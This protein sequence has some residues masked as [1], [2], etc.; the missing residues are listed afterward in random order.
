MFL[1]TRGALL[2]VTKSLI[3]FVWPPKQSIC[4]IIKK[5]FGG[6]L[7][8]KSDIKKAFDTM[9]WKFLPQVIQAFGLHHTFC[10]W[11]KIILQSAKL[12]I[13][14]NGHSVGYF[15]CK[16]GVRQVIL[17]PCFFFVL[18]RMFSVELFLIWWLLGPFFR[19]LVRGHSRCNIP[20][21]HSTGQIVNF[22]GFILFLEFLYDQ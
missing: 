17:F 22:I 5:V 20:N 11:V 9:D 21:F 16:R 18:L 2:K 1:R 7:A 13:S 3:V 14:V 4:L 19:W 12:S 10:N 15:N 8:L 6:N